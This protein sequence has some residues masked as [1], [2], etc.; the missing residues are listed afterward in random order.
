MKS[1]AKSPDYVF[2]TNNSSTRVC[3][4]KQN[5][6]QTFDRKP[7]FSIQGEFVKLIYWRQRPML[8]LLTIVYVTGCISRMLRLLFP[9]TVADR[10]TEFFFFSYFYYHL[11]EIIPPK[12]NFN[13]LKCSR[14]F[15]FIDSRSCRG[16]ISVIKVK[17]GR[18]RETEKNIFI[19]AIYID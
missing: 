1:I 2:Q 18:G 19:F 15:F 13:I 16:K 5:K 6:V 9:E 14:G 4:G 10:F 12:C 11:N 8:T 17:G 7:T 3:K